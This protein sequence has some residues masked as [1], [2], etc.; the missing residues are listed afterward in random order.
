MEVDLSA[1]H[2]ERVYRITS[3]NARNVRHPLQNTWLERLEHLVGEY[4]AETVDRHFVTGAYE[5]THHSNTVPL[6]RYDSR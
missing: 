6:S 1:V 5:Y 2:H 3:C 4:F